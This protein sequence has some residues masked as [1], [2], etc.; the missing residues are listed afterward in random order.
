MAG[1]RR[2]YW[3]IRREDIVRRD[4]PSAGTM[5]SFSS[6]DRHVISTIP[7]VII[8]RIRGWLEPRQFNRRFLL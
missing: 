7:N 8:I 5:E 6:A 3:Y 2:R 4:R 1:T